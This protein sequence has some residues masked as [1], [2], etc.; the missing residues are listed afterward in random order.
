MQKPHFINLNLAVAKQKIVFKTNKITSEIS[1]PISGSRDQLPTGHRHRR[2]TNAE[3][4]QKPTA[5]KWKRRSIA[6]SLSQRPI[7]NKRHNQRQ[8]VWIKEPRH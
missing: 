4:E 7:E 3:G 5:Q 8:Q 1:Q 6:T 2:R